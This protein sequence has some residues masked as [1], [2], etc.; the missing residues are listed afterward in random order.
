MGDD[1]GGA[2]LGQ[3]I[4][5]PLD[6]GLRHAVQ[7]G[8]GLVQ[9][10]HRRVLQE[11]PGDGDALLLPAG[12]EHAALAHVGVE[13]LGHGHNV[14]VD[15]RPPGRRHHLV[16]GGV[17]AAVADILQDAV[18]EQ[19]H[20]L[21]HHADVTPKAALL[22]VAYIPAVDPDAARPHVVEPGDQAAQRGLASAGGAHHGD[23]L[24]GVHVEGHVMEDLRIVPLVGEG[25]VLH[26]DPALHALQLH[27]VR[28]VL[29]IRLQ[30]HQ[31]HEAA[32]ARHAVH[33]GLRQ[34]GQL[35]D[36]V[37]EGARIEAESD[38]VH[39][40]HLALHDEPAAH[41]DDHHRHDAHEELHGAHEPGHG[42][43]PLLLGGLEALVGPQ[44]LLVL[45]VLVGEGFGGAHPGDTG[46]DVGVDAR[47]VLLDHLGGPH[48]VLPVEVGHHQEHRDQQHHHQGQPPLDGEHDGHGPHHR[49]TGDEQVLRPVVG[50]LGDV[51][52]LGGHAAHEVARAVL[53]IEAEGE[54]LE[55]G[56]QVLADVRL[57]QHTEG[58]SPVA[59]GV[60]QRRPQEIGRDK[61]HD[62]GKKGP[63]PALG[64]ELVHAH[65]ADVGE[66]QVHHGDHQRTGHIQKKQPQM[67]PEIAQ[68]DREKALPVEIAG[69]HEKN[70]HFKS[71]YTS[72]GTPDGRKF[73][74]QSREPFP[75]TS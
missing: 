70:L 52:E 1:E 21:L 54:G 37:D 42:A 64:D 14:V 57:H 35:A 18:R 65:P 32:Q 15:L 38:E 5:G 36:G 13:A 27:G 50:Q 19:E 59:N 28:F 74:I 41:G 20:I 7:G 11:D 68:K 4:K 17:G 46:L 9:N 48:H 67:G 34:V 72:S 29:Q 25:H 43:I 56:E 49:D 39:V 26:V 71:V 31:V 69:V 30:A 62:H 40:V 75:Y 47:H 10:Q 51:E 23:G 8:G 55:V 53:V 63:I 22:H 2:A 33:Q 73:S 3:L 24:P 58:V 44:E 45:R 12:E 61:H 66:G 6:F 60:P 16:H